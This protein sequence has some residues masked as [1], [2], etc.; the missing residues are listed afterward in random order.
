MWCNA[1]PL[2]LR[3]YADVTGRDIHLMQE[4]DAVTLGA[5]ISGAVAKRRAWG[6]YLRVK[7]WL[8]PERLFR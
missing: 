1:Q 5:A 2:W 3:E 4:E 6:F 8:K 7:Q